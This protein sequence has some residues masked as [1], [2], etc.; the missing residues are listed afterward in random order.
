MEKLFFK[1]EK[2]FFEAKKQ[3]M[4]NDECQMSRLKAKWFKY[5]VFSIGTQSATHMRKTRLE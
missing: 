5:K 4:K 2:L 3:P 1:T